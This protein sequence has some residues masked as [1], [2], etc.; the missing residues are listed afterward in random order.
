[1]NSRR[2]TGATV[3]SVN[4]A[5]PFGVC[6]I[7]EASLN[8]AR[9]VSYPNYIFEILTHAGVF[10]TKIAVKELEASLAGLRVLVT[11]GEADLSA[12]LKQKLTD[13]VS[14]GGMWLSIGGI[15]GMES[16]LGVKRSPNTFSNWGGGVRS[17]GE[18]YLVPGESNHAMLAHVNRPLH[19][20]GGAA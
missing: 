14:A 12:S 7:G 9:T 10:H 15:A 13:W 16:L 11:V 20:F 2:S 3:N 18:G 6:V 1:M 8:A 17:L 5:V 19:Y 4:I